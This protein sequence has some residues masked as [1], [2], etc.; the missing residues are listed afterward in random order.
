MFLGVYVSFLSAG[1]LGVRHRM[2]LFN[3]NEL[4]HWLVENLTTQTT[5]KRG[6]D[7]RTRHHD[8]NISRAFWR[9]L[10]RHA[11]LGVRLKVQ[12]MIQRFIGILELGLGSVNLKRMMPEVSFIRNFR[13]NHLGSDLHPGAEA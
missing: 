13:A 8:W 2:L 11:W 6:V 3:G 12:R 1:Y 9:S 10:L 7:R 4:H 5:R